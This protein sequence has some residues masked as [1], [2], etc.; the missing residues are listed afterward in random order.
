M[1]LKFESESGIRN[2][3]PQC[4]KSVIESEIRRFFGRI[5]IP[6][7]SRYSLI[8]FTGIFTKTLAIIFLCKAKVSNKYGDKNFYVSI[9]VFNHLLT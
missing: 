1:L 9:N 3:N 6:D 4:K 2:P 7:S 8:K 5:A